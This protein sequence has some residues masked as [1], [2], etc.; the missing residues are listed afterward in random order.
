[1]EKRAHQIVSLRNRE[2]AEVQAFWHYLWQDAADYSFPR[3]DQIIAR[4][5]PGEDKSIK[6]YDDTAVFDSQEM[7]SGL[8]SV[9]FPIGQKAFGIKFKNRQVATIDRVR[10]W[11]LLATEITHDELYESNF[12]LQ[13]NDALRAGAS[14]FGTGCLYSEWNMQDGGLN[15]KE[16]TVPDFLIRENSGGR[17]DTV[18][19][20][21]YLTARQAAQE[22]GDKLPSEVKQDA[23]SLENENRRREF[24]HIVRPRAKRNP[25]L[26]D[27]LNMP[28]ES[29]FVDV[30][31][32]TVIK[33]GGYEEMPFHVFRWMKGGTETYGRGQATESLGSIRRLQRVW[34]DFV[35]LCNRHCDPP[36]EVDSGF[37][38]EVRTFAGA[39]N[40]V[41]AVGQT[42]KALDSGIL[43]NF[44]ATREIVE[45]LRGE[46]HERFYRDIFTQMMDLQGDRRTTVEIRARQQQALQRLAS[47]T[48]RLQSELLTP[49]IERSILLL[50][51]NGRIPPPPPELGGQPWGIEYMGPLALALQSQ[52]SQGFVQWVSEGA[53]LAPIIP[54]VLDNI[55]VDSGFRRRGEKLGVNI[56]DINPVES[57]AAIRDARAKQQAAQQAM[58]ATQVAADA[59]QKGSGAAE[60]GSPAAELMAAAKE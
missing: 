58:Q 20:T 11:G 7:A 40:R 55:N 57:V 21:F 45:L 24:I 22:F 56:E 30:K 18:I 12:M 4:N 17:V 33:E 41:M 29:L 34:K 60:E 10:R 27:S 9:T 54:S 8:S 31:T 48:A 25:R 6:L 47:P 43:G 1:M 16:Y 13:Y 52:Q 36:R 5:T 59:Y 23:D 32:E 3:K 37:E 26:S 14:T 35:D 39:I 28:W 51:R 50:I 42:I 2:Q 19:L 53:Q 44:P 49:L 46:V 38:G 15:Y